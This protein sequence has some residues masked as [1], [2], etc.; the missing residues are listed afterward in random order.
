MRIKREVL[1]PFPGGKGSAKMGQGGWGEGG[2][3]ES[4]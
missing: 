3:P 4:H 2:E 1:G